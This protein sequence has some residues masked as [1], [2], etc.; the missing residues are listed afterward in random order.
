[1]S[2]TAVVCV[3]E[4]NLRGLFSLLLVDAGALVVVA[5][6]LDEA[7]QMLG[8][9]K[10]EL[11]VVSQRG[12]AALAEFFKTVRTLSPETKHLLLA[13]REDVDGVLTL[14]AT[15]LTEALLQPVNPKRAVAAISRMLGKDKVVATVPVAMGS[16]PPMS[17]DAGYRPTHLVA[18]SGRMRRLI[19]ELWAARSDPVGVILRGEAGV[20]FELVAREYQ[21]MD[22]DSDGS[23]VVLNN[24]E[25]DV[26]TLATQLSLDRLH[27]GVPRTYFVS[28]V[29][30]L[31]KD[32]EKPLLEFLRRARRQRDREKPLRIVFAAHA[33]DER[34]VTADSEFLEELQ[35]IVPAVVTIPSL[36][37]RVEDVSLIAR[38]VLA[39]M[40]AIN[41]E[42]RAR[43]IH[44]AA[45]QWLSA[46]N[47][48]GNYRELMSVVRQSILDCPNREL[49]PVHF[50]RLTETLGDPEEAAAARV[51]DAVQ[52]ASL[53]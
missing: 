50:G 47:W 16:M 18:R 41:P 24:G 32:R 38:Q 7:E 8:A 14:F 45:L 43:S 29:E 42:L 40:T 37:D 11:C 34:G 10:C 52:R 26:E 33:C 39:G 1:M 19:S 51:L 6:D 12:E 15:G 17:T 35:F 9:R 21:A 44:P 3:A 49:S 36:R 5:A 30:K 31:A 20:E 27:D 53:K 48:R 46:R 2:P 22:G 13:N 28:D 25:L 4:A 23:L